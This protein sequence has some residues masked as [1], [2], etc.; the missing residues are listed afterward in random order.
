MSR[1]TPQQYLDM[2]LSEQIPESAWQKILKERSD[3]RELYENHL[4]GI[5]EQL[6]RM[7]TPLPTV[8][9]AKK[10]LFELTLEDV[11]LENYTPQKFIKFPIAV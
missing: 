1:G 4:E 7:P 8:K 9:I 10:P 3:V 6:K 2:Y 5:K 11:Q